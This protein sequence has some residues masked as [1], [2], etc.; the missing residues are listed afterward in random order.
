MRIKL[1]TFRYSATL[2]G[3][4]DTPLV[5][6]IRNKELVAFREHFYLVNEVPHMSCILH[7][8]DAVIPKDVLGMARPEESVREETDPLGAPRKLEQRQAKTKRSPTMPVVCAGFDEA[9]RVL[10]NHLRE[11]RYAVAQHEGIDAFLVFTNR[12]LA[13]IVRRLPDSPTALMNIESIGPGKVRRYGA[14]LLRC[15]RG[16]PPGAVAAQEAK[17][18]NPSHG[19]PMAGGVSTQGPFVPQP[20]PSL[21][22]AT[23]VKQTAGVAG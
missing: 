3:F 14:Q 9:Q 12:Q 23:A 5:E 18:G 13:E 4:D 11:W 22:D 20:Q 19:D 16:E 17:L 7:Y 10:F 2:G 1:F 15:V 21:A 8:Q 6:F